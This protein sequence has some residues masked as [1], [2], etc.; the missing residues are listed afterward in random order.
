MSYSVILDEKTDIND[1]RFQPFSAERW[2]RYP[3]AGEEK[4]EWYRSAK[5]GLFLHVGINSLGMVDIS[6]PRHTHVKP[7]VGTGSIPDEVYDGWAKQFTFE[8]FCAEE[9]AQLAVDGGM[10]YV[11]IIAKHHDG[12]HM[13]DTEFSS[14]K[15]TNTPFKRDYL[16]ELIDA[17]RQAGLK[18]GL[19]YSQRDWVHPDYQ[20]IDLEKVNLLDHPPFYE[21]KRGEKYVVP[22]KHKKY[23]SYMHDT[24]LELMTKYGKIDILYWD[25][26]Y[27]GEMF[28]EEMWNSECLE[29]KVREL[30]PDILINNRA[31]CPG[32]FD[33]PET[34]VGFFQN[35]R[36]WETCMPLGAAWSYNGESPKSYETVL[37]Q[38]VCSVCGDGNYLL[39]IGAMPEGNLA[40]TDME[41]ICE[42]GCWL[43]TYGDSIYNTRGGPWK[44][45]EW[46]GSC[47]RGNTVYLHI[48]DRDAIKESIF[49]LLDNKIIQVKSLTGEI[50]ELII[51]EAGFQ[52]KIAE[53]N[54]NG[55]DCIL[56][57]TLENPVDAALVPFFSQS[58]D[59]KAYD[60]GQIF[61]DSPKTVEIDNT[62]FL[63]AIL[64]ESEETGMIRIDISEEGTEWESVYE[65][66]ISNKEEITVKRYEAGAYINGRSC[67]MVRISS[68]I[69]AMYQIF[70]AARE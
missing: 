27:C 64:L 8:K 1:L 49:S 3:F 28:V 47:Y 36:C 42:I 26:D 10:R 17:F 19:Y 6:W 4:L 70:T 52:I 29:Q 62:V 20:P 44:T 50:P 33:T 40:S 34:F 39:S 35:T 37:R 66:K 68:G 41:R 21:M 14:Y 32:D 30:W 15:I 12:F 61:A 48:F 5:Y 55:G 58:V 45:G 53:E 67:R 57:L 11:V 46:G 65:G 23:I 60:E 16:K 18:I 38:L 7:D 31:S 69:S 22:P 51:L 63:S 56:E 24:V 2:E 43:K 59:R 54:Q 25:A 13:W 9:W